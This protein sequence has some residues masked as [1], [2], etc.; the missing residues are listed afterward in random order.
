[1]RGLS[2]ETITAPPLL[3]LIR[4][5]EILATALAYRNWCFCP[6][7]ISNFAALP[8]IHTSRKPSAIREVYQLI[9]HTSI[10]RSFKNESPAIDG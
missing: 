7:F 6:S 5:T 9:D 1:M 4:L 10:M 2:S 8:T 3:D